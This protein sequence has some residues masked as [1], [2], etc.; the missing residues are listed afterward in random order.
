MWTFYVLYIKKQKVKVSI[1]YE[2]SM[3][4]SPN[5]SLDKE[6]HSIGDPGRQGNVQNLE[7]KT[8]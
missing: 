5:P 6:S 4:L 1:L 3:K 8:G 2:K 7:A